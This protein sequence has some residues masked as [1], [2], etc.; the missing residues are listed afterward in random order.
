MYMFIVSREEK[1]NHCLVLWSG[2]TFV[3][4]YV[5]K[6]FGQERGRAFFWFTEGMRKAGHLLDSQ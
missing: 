1:T 2:W 4:L 3:Y 6:L 5:L